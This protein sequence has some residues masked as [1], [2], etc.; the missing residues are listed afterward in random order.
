MV[1][2]APHPADLPGP[3]HRAGGGLRHR[4]VRAAALYD[5]VVRTSLDNRR[6]LFIGGTGDGGS[7]VPVLSTA[8]VYLPH[9]RL[10]QEAFAAVVA[11]DEIDTVVLVAGVRSLFKLPNDYSIEDLPASGLGDVVFD[12]LGRAVRQLVDS[13]KK[14]VL[15]VDNPTLPDPK[16]CMSAIGAPPGVVDTTPYL[17]DVEGGT[18]STYK[19]RRLYSYTDHISD[20]AAGIIGQD[21]NR[22]IAFP[23]NSQ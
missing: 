18:C 17:C 3:A 15:V 5:G 16:E 14:V 2:R 13:G 10:V 12:G 8:A 9:Q 20:Y 22:A 19:G 11:N 23:A 6:W 7:T 1:L 4:V 21:L